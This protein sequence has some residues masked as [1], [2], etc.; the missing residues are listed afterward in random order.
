MRPQASKPRKPTVV[1]LAPRDTDRWYLAEMLRNARRAARH[2]RETGIVGYCLTTIA[3]DG[4]MGRAW[5][6][7]P[8][9]ITALIG[10][11]EI[12]RQELVDERLMAE[13]V[14]EEDDE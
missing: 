5:N 9:H 8:Q 13:Q 10:A 6:C 2:M 3:S 4:S 11:Q 14:R 12:A 7:N 1:R